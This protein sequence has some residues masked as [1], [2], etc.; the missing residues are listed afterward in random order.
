MIQEPIPADDTKITTIN[1]LKYKIGRHGFVYCWLN[2]E[3]VKSTKTP[4]E[5]TPRQL[6][7]T[8]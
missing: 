8:F 2:N 1:T 3:W 7:R 6:K 5:L 4:A